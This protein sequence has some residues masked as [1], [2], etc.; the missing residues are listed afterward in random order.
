MPPLTRQGLALELRFRGEALSVQLFVCCNAG[1]LD[2]FPFDECNRPLAA[3]LLG[4]NSL[5]RAHCEGWNFPKTLSQGEQTRGVR[6]GL[7]LYENLA[8]PSSRRPFAECPLFCGGDA[9]SSA[10][11]CL[12]SR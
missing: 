8:L 5:S 1:T 12:S 9:R 4:A 6:P 7:R 3:F 2:T 11:A 10:P